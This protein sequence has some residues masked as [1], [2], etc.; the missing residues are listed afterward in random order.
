[1]RQTKLARTYAKSLLNLA[2]EKGL[3][4]EVK[5]DMETIFT[6]CIQSKDLQLMLDSPVVST[7]KKHSVLKSIFQPNVSEFTYSFIELV[8]KKGREAVL[9]SLA[10]S[11]GQLYLE[12]KNILK[13]V[14]KSVDG[15]SEALK[16][17]VAEL[18]KATYQKEVLIEEIKDPSLIGGF[19]ITVGDRQVDAS[20]SKKLAKL[21]NA[22][23]ENPYIA[24]I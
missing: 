21:H 20:V 12:H 16:V 7:D 1:M 10:N 22:F 4:E 9:V 24:E 8:A 2:V 18:V 15:V 3:L 13:A 5:T 11:F 23:S 17:K 19:I 6:V 14:V